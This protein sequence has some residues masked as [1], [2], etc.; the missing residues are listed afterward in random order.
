MHK[1]LFLLLAVGVALAK[2]EPFGLDEAVFEIG[3]E[4]H[5]GCGYDVFKDLIF[6]EVQ[7]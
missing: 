7:L 5:F 3:H 4:E 2:E 1:L 6:K